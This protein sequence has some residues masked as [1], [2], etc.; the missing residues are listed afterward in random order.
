MSSKAR[1][2]AK[3]QK[4]GYTIE[5]AGCDIRLVAPKG[6]CFD[7]DHHEVISEYGDMTFITK[8]EAWK[9]VYEHIGKAEVCE[10]E[11]CDWCGGR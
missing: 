10:I 3:A 5:D 8:A 7:Q 4:L 9:D 1:V 2:E 11:D 6:Y